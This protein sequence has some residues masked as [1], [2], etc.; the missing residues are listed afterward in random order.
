M[1]FP[2]MPNMPNGDI[3]MTIGRKHRNQPK[4]RWLESCIE[5]VFKG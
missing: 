3:G 2:H 1:Q 4:M 5:E